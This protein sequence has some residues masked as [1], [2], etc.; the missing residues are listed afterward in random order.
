MICRRPLRG[1]D[2]TWSF[3][4]FLQ[5]ASLA[6]MV[7]SFLTP[8]AVHRLIMVPNIATLHLHVSYHCWEAGKQTTH[9][10]CCRRRHSFTFCQHTSSAGSLSTVESHFSHWRT[11]TSLSKAGFWRPYFSVSGRTIFIFVGKTTVPPFPFGIARATSAVVQHR[12]IQRCQWSF[13]L[14]C[15]WVLL[16]K[17]HTWG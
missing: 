9:K 16:G 8:A 11:Q 6:L 17:L 12:M 14:S 15:V 4:T 13:L 7:H 3:V 5:E 10:P 1:K 2:V